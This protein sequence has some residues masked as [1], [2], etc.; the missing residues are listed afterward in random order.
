MMET[1]KGIGQNS[2]EGG[3][4]DCLIFD[5]WFAS[6]K[7]AESAMVIGAELIVMVKKNT[8]GFCK[9]TIEKLTK[10]F[11]GGSYLMLRSKPMVP[12]NRPRIAIGYKYRSLREECATACFQDFCYPPNPRKNRGWTLSNTA[13]SRMSGRSPQSTSY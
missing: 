1:K 3:T 13:L 2:I 7:A 5:S 10:D 4:N 6:K 11:P 8:K 12:G 9:E